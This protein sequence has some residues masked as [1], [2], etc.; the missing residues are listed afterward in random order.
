MNHEIHAGIHVYS[1]L[2]IFGDI[3]KNIKVFNILYR[4][5][6]NCVGNMYNFFIKFVVIVPIHLH[7]FK[8]PLENQNVQILE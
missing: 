7:Q 2:I 5:I 4:Y 1:H 6:G 3:R 8:F